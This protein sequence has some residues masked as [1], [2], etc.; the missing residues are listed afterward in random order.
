MLTVRGLPIPLDQ[1][2]ATRWEAATFLRELSADLDIK[3]YIQK[4]A[5]PTNSR[6]VDKD[7]FVR[8]WP[9]SHK[10]LGRFG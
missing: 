8:K 10:S 2:F 4:S 5:E 3:L 9:G 6:L 7:G 1:R